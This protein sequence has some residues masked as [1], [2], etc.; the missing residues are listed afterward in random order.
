MGNEVGW[1]V[2]EL[3]FSSSFY[4][5]TQYH[6]L[7]PRGSFLLCNLAREAPFY[8]PQKGYYGI[9]P[10]DLTSSLQK[11]S[12]NSYQEE[13]LFSIS[14]WTVQICFCV[15][16]WIELYIHLLTL[17]NLFRVPELHLMHTYTH[18]TGHEETWQLCLWDKHLDPEPT[19]APLLGLPLS[20]W[21]TWT[22]YLKSL[23]FR[24]QVYK[25][26]K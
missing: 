11:L 7:P 8:L 22:N 10:S 2:E 9:F 13:E 12:H 15:W 26:G 3:P 20:T 21:V 1:R 23:S 6:L 25:T 19:W 17:R 18:E 24:F 5:N 16:G 14:L 4:Y